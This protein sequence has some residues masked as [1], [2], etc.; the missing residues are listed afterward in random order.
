MLIKKIIIMETILSFGTY[1]VPL[2]SKNL[3]ASYNAPAILPLEMNKKV[4]FSPNGGS[5]GTTTILTSE[6]P[7]KGDLKTLQDIEK[8]MGSLLIK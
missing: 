5:S 1:D 2:I 6:N 7:T 8:E 4:S 3:S